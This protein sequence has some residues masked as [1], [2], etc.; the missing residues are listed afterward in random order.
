MKVLMVHKFFYRRGGAELFFL[1]TGSILE[2]HGHEV[3]YF[4][5]RHPANLPSSYSTYFAQAPEYLQ[6]NIFKR[7]LS[8]GKLV[9]SLETKRR[10]ARMLSDFQPDLVHVFHIN[11]HLSPSILVACAEA[12]VPVVMSCNDYKH[13]CPNYKLYHH[14]RICEDCRGGRFFHAVLNRCCKDSL[15]FSFASCLEAYL[16]RWMRVYSRYVHT[17]TFATDFMARETEKFWGRGSFRWRKLPNPLIGSGPAVSGKSDDYIL[18]F[19]RLAE[20]KGVDLLIRSM[21]YIPMVRLK[22]FGDGPEV[23]SLKE[24]V[25]SLGLSNIEFLKPKWGEY[26]QTVLDRCRFVVVPSKWYENLPYTILHAFSSGKAVIG[27]ARGGISEVVKDGAFGLL[28]PSEDTRIL[29]EKIKE[30]WDNP[31]RA[32][33]MGEAA[34]KFVNDQFNEKRFYHTL[35]EIY[36]EVLSEFSPE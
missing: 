34:R 30:L 7:A 22:I 21:Q 18:Y 13:I 26:L 28:Y 4:S 19:G 29:A 10:F 32:E 6:G 17:Y 14:G 16:H 8:I 2:R 15:A 33:A 1:E 20:E 11:V 23:D 35:M 36:G 25:K 27:S 12:G 3:A 5:S 31:D 24:L 9:Y